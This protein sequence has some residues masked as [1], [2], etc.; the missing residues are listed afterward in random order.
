[1]TGLLKVRAFRRFWQ[2]MERT[3]PFLLVFFSSRGMGSA[4]GRQLIWGKLRRVIISTCPPLARYLQ[5][6]YK[7]SGG[8]Q[9]C[10]ASC[11]LLFQCP[12]WDENSNLCTVYE[13]RPNICRLFP[14][15]PADIR[16]RNLVSR[17]IP[18][19]Y[20][21]PRTVDRLE[22]RLHKDPTPVPVVLKSE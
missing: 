13:D 22:K 12:H 2:L 20:V 7:L 3:W 15:T 6:Q 18:C 14:I 9:G 19:G 1:M 16:D 8:C 10:G 5:K 4:E 21:F 17:K 11:N